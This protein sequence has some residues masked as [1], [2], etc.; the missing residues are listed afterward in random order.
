MDAFDA[1]TLWASEQIGLL[2]L[3]AILVSLLMGVLVVSVLGRLVKAVEKKT[4]PIHRLLATFT[5]RYLKE[6]EPNLALLAKAEHI[7]L[8]NF[9]RYPAY[10]ESVAK[11]VGSERQTKN[12]VLYVSQPG[13]E[14]ELI[15]KI[16]PPAS[17]GR[18]SGLT[19]GKFLDDGVT[20]IDIAFLYGGTGKTPQRLVAEVA[21]QPGRGISIVEQRLE[22][23]AA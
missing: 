16:L 4:G 9:G 7:E 5:E 22:R 3:L 19:A 8:V 18:L 20:T 15:A 1:F 17:S 2:V 11:L 10:L 12:V 21:L 14:R 23:G 13:N 6:T